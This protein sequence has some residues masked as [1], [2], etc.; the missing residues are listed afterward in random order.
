M[1]HVCQQNVKKVNDSVI[2]GSMWGYHLGRLMSDKSRV[3]FLSFMV[4]HLNRCAADNSKFEPSIMEKFWEEYNVG[5]LQY[6][7]KGSRLSQLMIW[8]K[9]QVIR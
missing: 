6:N 5:G 7:T 4:E 2:V 1:E 9:N 8:E 3:K